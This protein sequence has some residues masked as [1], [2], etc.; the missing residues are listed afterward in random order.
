MLFIALTGVFTACKPK[1][2]P[3][4]IQSLQETL[5]Q[6]DKAGASVLASAKQ[7]S[8]LNVLILSAPLD[9]QKDPRVADMA[10]NVSR[11]PEKIKAN[12]DPLKEEAAKF[13]KMLADYQ[14]GKVTTEQVQKELPSFKV[15]IATAE[16]LAAAMTT[17][18][19]TFNKQYRALAQELLQKAS[20]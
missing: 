1:A 20:K 2:D 11:Y 4:V 6:A 17:E 16:Q 10:A 5:Q 18:Y 9:L 12:A 13:G 7:F 15:S 8:D 3:Q 19:E 14:A